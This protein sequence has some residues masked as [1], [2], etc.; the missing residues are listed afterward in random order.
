MLQALTCDSD[1]TIDGYVD[2]EGVETTLPLPPYRDG[3]EYLLGVFMVGAY[4]EILGDMHNLFGD[5]DSVNVELTDDGY[6]LSGAQGGDTVE[7]VLRYVHFDAED[8]MAEYRRRVAQA[9]MPEDERATALEELE[10]GLRG[11]TYLE[12]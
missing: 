10:A 3:E 12:D 6:R 4:Q 1:G 7:S 8:L 11:Y 9:A 5:T 2:R